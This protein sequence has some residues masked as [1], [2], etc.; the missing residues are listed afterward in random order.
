MSEIEKVYDSENE[1]FEE[2]EEME[3]KNDKNDETDEE[4]EEES[5]DDIPKPTRENITLE[6][7][8]DYEDDDE[9]DDEEDNNEEDEEEDEDLPKNDKKIVN[10]EDINVNINDEEDDDDEEYDENYLQKLDKSLE[11]DIIVDFHPEL[12]SH[13]YDEIEILSRV[14]RDSNGDIIDPFHRT[15][16][17]ITKY[18]K[19]RILGERAKQ[20]NAGAKAFVS[21]PE[22]MIDGYLIALKEYEEKKIPFILKR[23]LPNGAM[24]YWKLK[25]LEI[26]HP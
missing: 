26:I 18:E 8:D 2:E 3:E 10:Y 24:E 6:R 16:P 22:N 20:I 1:D 14:V 7:D 12:K 13:N 5:D 21:I 15:L 9:D 19:A 4:E 11:D 17:F 25:D 23:P